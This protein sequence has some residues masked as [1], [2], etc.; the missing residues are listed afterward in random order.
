MQQKYDFCCSKSLSQ[1]M[2]AECSPFRHKNDRAVQKYH[3]T[4]MMTYLKSG[5]KPVSIL[6]HFL[7][8]RSIAHPLRPI[9]ADH[10][11]YCPRYGGLK[12][13]KKREKRLYFAK[14]YR[15]ERTKVVNMIRVGLRV[16]V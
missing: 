8:L 4:Q 3:G 12:L 5:S 2:R 9:P 14:P 1:V 13:L 11:H 10:G 16:R 6:G 15:A 7:N